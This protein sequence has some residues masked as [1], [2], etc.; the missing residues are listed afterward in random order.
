[1][2]KSIPMSLEDLNKAKQDAFGVNNK[3]R[4]KDGSLKTDMGKES[5]LKLLVTEL[6]HQDPTQPMQ[7]KEFIAQ[8]AQFS[9][10]EQM[11]SINKS[12]QEL[13]KSANAGEAY[14]LLGKRVEGLDTMRGERIAGT[15]DKIFRRDNALRLIVNGRELDLLEIHAVYPQKEGGEKDLQHATRRLYERSALQSKGNVFDNKSAEAQRKQ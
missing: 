11:T 8:M 15:V 4:R 2:D 6:R 13:N 10:L 14:A 5:F 3:L 1:M 9:S 12:I 7:D